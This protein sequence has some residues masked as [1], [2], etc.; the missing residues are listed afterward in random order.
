MSRRFRYIGLGLG[1]VVCLT[2]LG[3]P[4][5]RSIAASAHAA[6]ASAATTITYWAH[7]DPN[8]V[9]ADQAVIRR[10]EHAYPSIHIAYQ[11]FPYD[12]YI[13]K[14]QAAFRAHTAAVMERVFG[15]WV[16]Q[17]AQNG[18]F[19]PV[20]ASLA[21]G[22]SSRY[23]SA[24]L[25]A[26]AYNGRY[27]GVPYEY[28]L[29][30]GGMLVNLA[31]LKRAHLAP[32]KTWAQ[33]VHAATALTVFRKGKMVQEG[34]SFAG[35]NA[36]GDTDSPTFLYLSMILQ[37]G[38]T[39][40]AADGKHVDFLTPA[41][42]KAWLAESALVTSA[43]VNSISDFSGD[44]YEI[45]FRGQAAMAMRGPWAISAGLQE[46]PHTTIPYCYCALP[47]FAGSKPYFAAESGW[48]NVVNASASPAER[49]A[50][51]TFI[52]FASRTENVR[53]WTVQ[54]TTVPALKVLQN[55]P[56]I[57]KV[58]PY[59]RISFA[60]LPYGRWVGPVQDRDTFWTDIGNALTAVELGQRKPLDALAEAQKEINTMIDQH[61][62]P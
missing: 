34:F 32:P 18:L 10:F 33:L 58:S 1:V 23:F 46:F 26:Y 47:P 13:R 31:L 61:L 9:A 2:L 59:M 36:N 38:A 39:Y 60:V 12:V 24:A 4:A 7:N 20:P 48:G 35:N 57:L 62:G 43:K 37:Q 52:S 55:D 30:N 44:S 28:N 17:Y 14:L 50:A 21:A 3:V 51:W 6:R 56:Q 29:E 49:A 53:L 15:T 11:A 19:D 42:K 54:S 45:F 5:G 27:Y 22:M 41:G 40:W 16:P 8:F 25:G